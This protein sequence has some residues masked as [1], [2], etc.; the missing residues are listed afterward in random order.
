MGRYDYRT[1]DLLGAA[2]Y[3]ALYFDGF[4]GGADEPSPSE[5]QDEG[6][7]LY[8]A[9]LLCPGCQHFWDYGWT[10]EGECL[11]DEVA[12][13]ELDSEIGAAFEQVYGPAMATAGLPF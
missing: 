11:G 13:A 7:P 3:A 1:N 6:G 9:I 4:D 5:L 8:G 12:T 2:R 10:T